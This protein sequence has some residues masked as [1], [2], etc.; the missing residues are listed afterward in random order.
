MS[1]KSCINMIASFNHTQ[2]LY[3]FIPSF[4]FSILLISCSF[5]KCTPLTWMYNRIWEN[6]TY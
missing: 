1:F 3:S 6:Y 2:V 4:D 5:E